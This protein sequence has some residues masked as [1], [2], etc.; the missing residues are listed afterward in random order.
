MIREKLGEEA[1]IFFT[2]NEE[3]K[4]TQCFLLTYQE[5]NDLSV[6]SGVIYGDIDL[7]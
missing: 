3:S 2:F 7:Y 4:L 1:R 5:L 6:V